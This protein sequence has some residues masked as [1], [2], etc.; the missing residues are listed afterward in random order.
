MKLYVPNLEFKQKEHVDTLRHFADRARKSWLS[1]VQ[2]I[3]I[4]PRPCGKRSG[5][6]AEPWQFWRKMV[7]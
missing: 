5:L 2:M 6:I 4:S 7:A 1:R 3:G